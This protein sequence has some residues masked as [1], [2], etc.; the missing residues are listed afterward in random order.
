MGQKVKVLPCFSPIHKL[1]LLLSLI[2]STSWLK[3][4]AK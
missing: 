3:N 4:C 1:S 2:T